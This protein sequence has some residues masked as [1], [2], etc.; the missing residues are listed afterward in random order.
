MLFAHCVLFS[1]AF[2]LYSSTDRT[3]TFTN[4]YTAQ[5]LYPFYVY[6]VVNMTREGID[7]AVY[8]DEYS[9]NDQVIS[10]SAIERINKDLGDDNYHDTYID[11]MEGYVGVRP[12][13]TQQDMMHLLT[14]FKH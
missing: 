3:R 5:R 10:V 11:F 13:Y 1:T 7:Q 2:N 14:L 9:Q 8:Q 12:G 6:N 4:T